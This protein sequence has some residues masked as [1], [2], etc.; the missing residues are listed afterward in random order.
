MEV[1]IKQSGRVLTPPFWGFLICRICHIHVC[2]FDYAMKV[3]CILD[4]KAKNRKFDR[5]LFLIQL[6][7]I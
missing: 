5:Q 4:S 3:S 1:D 7:L 2:I 6:P